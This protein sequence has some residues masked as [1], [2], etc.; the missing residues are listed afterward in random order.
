VDITVQ[1]EIF[2]VTVPEGKNKPYCCSHGF[3]LRSGPNSQKLDRDSIMDFFHNEGHIKY[4]VIVRNELPVDGNFNETAYNDFIRIAQ[5]SDVLGRDSTLINLDCAAM[6]DD[7]LCFTNLG[8]LF[9][10]INDKDMKFRHTGVVCAL[11]K[12]FDKAN[13]IDAKELNGNI[14]SN[15][16]DAVAFL[17]KHLRISYVIKTLQRE[18]VLE[19]PEDAL[20]EAIINAVCH[21]NYFESGARVMI[22]IYYDRVDIVSP[23]GVCKGITPENFGIISITR[24]SLIA[25]MLHRIRYIEQMGTGIK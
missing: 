22:E 11:F 7:K 4:D 3:F 25:G 21:R 15:I 23:G 18:E 24:N 5:I 2:I 1:D 6:V 9:F 8:A 17:K 19:L 14:V 13:I 16:D 20:R 10:R 12:G